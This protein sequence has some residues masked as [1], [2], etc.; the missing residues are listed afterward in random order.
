VNV[1]SNIEP[2]ENNY[3]ALAGAPGHSYRRQIP[4]AG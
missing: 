1:L 3:R 4:I 2:L